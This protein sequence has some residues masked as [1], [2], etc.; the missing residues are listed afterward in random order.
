MQAGTHVIVAPRY[1]A[2]N[3]CVQGG[4]SEGPLL[5]ENVVERLVNLENRNVE[6][7]RQ[8]TTL[9]MKVNEKDVGNGKEA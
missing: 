5:G 4:R 1:K 8:L 3:R 2:L 6:L 9:R 7:E